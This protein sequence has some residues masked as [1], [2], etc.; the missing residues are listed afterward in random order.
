MKLPAHEQAV[1]PEEK[2][3]NYLLSFTHGDGRSKAKFFSRFG[4]SAD[5]ADLFAEALR[6]HAAEYD[7]TEVE[8]TAFGVSYTIEGEL[9]A[10]DGRSPRVR[11]VWFIKNGQTI[12]TLVTAYPLHR[13]RSAHD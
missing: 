5:A 12:P 8:Q 11:V 7:V 2:I 1:V 4:F 6:R 9:H 10:P 3:V 13:K